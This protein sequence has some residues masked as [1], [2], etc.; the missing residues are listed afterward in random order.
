MN[1]LYTLL[2]VLASLLMS[3]HSVAQGSLASLDTKNGFR[4]AKIGMPI[5]AFKGMI[6]IKEDHPD[7]N[8]VF[9]RYIRPSD[10]LMLGDIPLKTILYTFLD[11]R[12]HSIWVPVCSINDNQKILAIFTTAYGK[13]DKLSTPKHYSWFGKNVTLGFLPV[14]SE[15]LAR[16]PRVIGGFRFSSS[17]SVEVF[18]NESNTLLNKSN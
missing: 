8:P 15:E 7:K 4:D 16:N 5:S 14:I 11:K 13:W 6:L 10:K 9:T 17:K 12:L 18:R 2:L 1:Y 3:S